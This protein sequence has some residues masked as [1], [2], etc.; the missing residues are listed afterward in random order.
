MSALTNSATPIAAT[1]MSA[2]RQCSA[3][4]RLREWQRVTVALACLFFLAED[5][6]HR[7]A[8]DVA[9]AKDHD[10]GALHR[11]AGADEQLVNPAGVHGTKPPPSPSISLPTFTG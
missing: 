7:F 9:P 10:L 4:S 8:D 1:M 6:R 5:R 2:R 3:T 11:H